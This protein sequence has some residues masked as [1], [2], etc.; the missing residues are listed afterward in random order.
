MKPLE[1]TLATLGA[2]TPD[3]L[4]TIRDTINDMLAIYEA[5]ADDSQSQESSS[6]KV[7]GLGHIEYKMIRGYGP[8]AYLRRWRGKSLTSTYLGKAKS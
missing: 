6:V 2:L 3:E 1:R 4:V 7:V 5:E 8:Y